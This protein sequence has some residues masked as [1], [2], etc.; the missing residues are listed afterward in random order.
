MHILPYDAPS[1]ESKGADPVCEWKRPRVLFLLISLGLMLYL[2]IEIYTEY[3]EWAM[4]SA[5]AALIV[6]RMYAACMLRVCVCCMYVAAGTRGRTD[7]F[8]A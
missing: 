4:L 6:W 8:D 1:A 7:S 3:T 5:L 2:L